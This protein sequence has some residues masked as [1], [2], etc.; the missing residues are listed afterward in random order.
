[1]TRTF[2]LVRAMHANTRAGCHDCEGVRVR[3]TGKNAQATA[4]R[5]T[6]ATGHTTW[7]ELELTFAYRDPKSKH[8]SSEN[9]A[10]LEVPSG[11]SDKGPIYG[12]RSAVN[13]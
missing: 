3:W 13:S 10:L 12:P 1:M 2:E 11:S 9:H 6:I 7:V 5:H 4:A 8:Q